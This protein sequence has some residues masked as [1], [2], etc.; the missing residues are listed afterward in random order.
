MATLPQSSEK[1][2][3]ASKKASKVPIQPRKPKIDLHSTISCQSFPPGSDSESPVDSIS[4]TTS[5]QMDMTL[6]QRIQDT[7]D[8]QTPRKTWVVQDGLG[9]LFDRWSSACPEGDH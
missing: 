8:L 3:A 5:S 4:S 2:L 9:L 6:S 1:I 7:L